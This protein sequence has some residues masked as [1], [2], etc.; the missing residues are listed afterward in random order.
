MQ[1]GFVPGRF[2]VENSQFMKLL[3]ATLDEKDEPGLLLFLDMEK[4][5]DR[6][7]WEFLLQALEAMG[8]G[9]SGINQDGS[10]SDNK[11]EGFTS[12]V[13]L[14]YDSE[15]PPRRQL[16]LNGYK[17]KWF[18]LQSGVAQGC[19]LSPLLFLF[20]TEGLSRLLNDDPQVEGIIIGEKEVKFSMFADDTALCLRSYKS[21]K[22]VRRNLKT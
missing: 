8:F 12:M 5:F 11:A 2:I 14:M 3:Q 1:T 7:S 13:K 15:K 16:H 21:I 20:V 22:R 4:A 9:N 19:P 10:T 6:V 18:H 17:G